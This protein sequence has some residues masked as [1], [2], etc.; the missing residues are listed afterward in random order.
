ME[1]CLEVRSPDN[2]DDGSSHIETADSDD[3]I[4]TG[5]GDSTATDLDDITA[6]GS[7]DSTTKSPG[8]S[9]LGFGL[10]DEEKGS[11]RDRDPEV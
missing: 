8:E 3:N 7:V 11:L 10:V 4:T 2:D 5:V 9:G 6:T 1:E